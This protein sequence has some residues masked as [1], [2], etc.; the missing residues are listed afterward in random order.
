MIKKKTKVLSVR[1]PVELVEAIDKKGP[2]REQLE[3]L[4]KKAFLK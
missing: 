3:P 1:L 4:L 2:R